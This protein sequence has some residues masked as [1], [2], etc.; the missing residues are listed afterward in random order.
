MRNSF[1][2]FV[3]ILRVESIQ[4]NTKKSYIS[5]HYYTLTENNMSFSS[6]CNCFFL[7]DAS[8]AVPDRPKRST[9]PK[10]F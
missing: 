6:G 4:S 8:D 1:G 3:R 2:V 9:V 10:E 5:K 7:G